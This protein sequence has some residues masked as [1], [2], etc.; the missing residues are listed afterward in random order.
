MLLNFADT[1]VVGVNG[2]VGRSSPLAACG[3]TASPNISTYNVPV[4]SFSVA[5]SMSATIVCE[6][7]TYLITGCVHSTCLH[8]LRIL[9][10]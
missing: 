6:S 10:A 1:L 9:L 3:I 7:N 8:V 4:F 2:H 5:T